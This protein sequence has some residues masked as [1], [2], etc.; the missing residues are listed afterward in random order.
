MDKLIDT[1]AGSGPLGILCAVLLVILV[2]VSMFAN[3]LL[4]MYVASQKERIAEGIKILDF[5]NKQNEMYRALRDAT[6]S[7]RRNR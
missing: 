4:E 1:L 3:R 6:L 2:A 5:I 7:S